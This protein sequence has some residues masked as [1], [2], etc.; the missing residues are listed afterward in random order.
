MLQPRISGTIR[1]MT[2]DNGRPVVSDPLR[3][4]ARSRPTIVRGSSSL[5][6]VALMMIDETCSAV[7]VKDR[8]GGHHV[9][10]ERDIVRA[11]SGGAD[12]DKEWT[13]EVGQT[14]EIP[15]KVKDNGTRK[16]NL[17]IDVSAASMGGLL[18]SEDFVEDFAFV[19]PLIYTFFSLAAAI[20]LMT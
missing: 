2:Q 19:I 9:V 4:I 3:S 10:T 5:R 20:W 12:P 17:T 13:V 16:G 11:L 6:E 1:A 7:V 18:P 15:I 14:L 8:D